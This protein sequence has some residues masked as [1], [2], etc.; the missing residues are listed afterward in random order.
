MTPKHVIKEEEDKQQIPKKLQML[1]TFFFFFAAWIQTL[2]I[3]LA[4]IAEC[5]QVLV[6]YKL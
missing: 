1:V 2:I 5:L 4:A 6:Q 3:Q